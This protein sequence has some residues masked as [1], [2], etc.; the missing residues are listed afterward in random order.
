MS[1]PVLNTIVAESLD[2]IAT[3]LEKAVKSGQDFNKAAQE[4]LSGILKESKKVIFNGDN[5]TEEWHQ[6]AEKRGLPNLKNTVDSLPV[7]VRK[8]SIDLFSKYKVYSERELKSR[9][10]ILSENYVKTV[11][12]E[13]QLTSMMGRTMILPAALRYQA[14]VASAVNATKAAGVDNSSQA[15]LLK[16]LTGTITDFQT[17]LSKLDK[18]LSHHADG[19]PYDHAKNSRDTV[20]PAMATVRSLGDK[21]ETTVADDLWPLPT[22]R[23]MLFIK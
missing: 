22:Y 10:A 8:D 15:E 21:L 12:I 7:I 3:N 6:E 19:E 16:S 13:G 18:A 4:L 5:Y 11:N 17:A 1:I 2:F 23:E 14:E 9:L 20:L